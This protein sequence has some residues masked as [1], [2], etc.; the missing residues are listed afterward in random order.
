MHWRKHCAD[1]LL[2]GNVFKDIMKRGK[3]LLE[4]VV[5]SNQHNYSTE[6]DKGFWLDI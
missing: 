6:N 4:A 3:I 1:L 5:K 2:F